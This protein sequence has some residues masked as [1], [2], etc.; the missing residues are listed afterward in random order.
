[1]SIKELLILV[2][3]NLKRLLA[4]LLILATPLHFAVAET[5]EVYLPDFERSFPFEGQRVVEP[6]DDI[7]FDVMRPEEFGIPVVQEE[8]NVSYVLTK[9]E[10][11]FTP[12]YH[13]FS[14]KPGPAVYIVAGTHGDERAGWYAASLLK[15][16]SLKAGAL[17]ILPQANRLGCEKNSRNVIGSL[18]L[19]RSYPGKAG[20][21]P[22]QNLAHAI[23]ED[24]MRVR[25]ALVLDLHEAAYYAKDKDFLGNKITFTDLDGIEKLFF[26]LMESAEEESLGA[27]PFGFVSPGVAGSLNSTASNGLGIPVLTVE[28]FR[29]FPI[30]QRVKD[31]V[32]IV[33]YCLRFYGMIEE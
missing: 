10:E 7:L 9:E 22:A 17:F 32:D 28:T 16:I 2:E 33:L 14:G 15:K 13:V 8:V 25:P 3:D 4:L 12:V 21:D 31:Q 18:D 24:I 6:N 26:S 19:N 23:Y 1:M 29:G 5:R 20:G 30:G 11:T 27:Y